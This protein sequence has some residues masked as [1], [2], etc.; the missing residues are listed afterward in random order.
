MFKIPVSLLHKLKVG[1]IYLF[2]SQLKGNI[3]SM[4]DIDLGI[5]FTDPD[6]LKDSLK[7]YSEL[8]LLF[9]RI[10]SPLFLDREMDIVFLQ[11]AS[12]TLQ[13]EVVTRGR[14]LYEISS[15]FRADY[16]EDVLRKYLDFKPLLDEMDKVCLEFFL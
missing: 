1:I 9:S 13:F 12:V 6:V 10:K 8:Y 3:T 2:G 5:V 11:K 14:V 7:V 4:S 15:K 16:A